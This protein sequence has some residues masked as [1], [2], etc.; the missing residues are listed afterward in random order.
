MGTHL[1]V[2]YGLKRVGLAISDSEGIV[3]NP[4][5]TIQNHNL[6]ETLSKIIIQENISTIVIGMPYTLQGKLNPITPHIFGL[7][8]KLQKLFPS[9]SIHTY[10]ERYTSKLASSAIASS[11]MKKKDRQQKELT[12]KVSAAIILN[13]YL[14]NRGNTNFSNASSQSIT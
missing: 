4:L 12:D 7:I 1:G 10:D 9:L 8:D 6:A 13:D 11:G 14:S 3:A 5:C 2:D